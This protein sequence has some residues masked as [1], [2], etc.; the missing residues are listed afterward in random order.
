MVAVL[1][2][3]YIPSLQYY[4]IYVSLFITIV[5]VKYRCTPIKE[6]YVASVG[7]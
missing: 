6:T 5:Q 2:W 3:Y 4:L 7:H 1:C